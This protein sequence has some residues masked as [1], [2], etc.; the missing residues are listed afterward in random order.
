MEEVE[1]MDVEVME[2]ADEKFSADFFTATS[3]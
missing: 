1:R 2:K 3:L